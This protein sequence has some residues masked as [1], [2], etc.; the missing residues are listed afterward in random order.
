[1]EGTGRTLDY[2][3]DGLNRLTSESVAGVADSGQNGTVSYLLDKVGNRET[4]T[5]SIASVG[6]QLFTFNPRDQFNA[7]TYDANGNTTVSAGVS[8]TV[9]DTWDY[10]AF[11]N[12]V[13]RTGST[14]NAYL[15]RGE[16]FD[17]DLGMYSLRA[18]FYNQ[19]T[20]RFWN[21]DSYEGS[22]ADPGSLH[23]YLYANADPVGGWDPS[24]NFN[25]IDMM[26]SV[27]IQGYVRAMAYPRIFSVV[28]FAVSLIIPMEAQLGMPSFG[29]GG[30]LAA[31][32]RTLVCDCLELVDG[33]IRVDV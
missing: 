25:L 31:V 12:V 32:E 5:S 17:A 16:Q 9:T 23:K 15:Y 19:A 10:D 30:G 11:G 7:D 33:D 29:A 26:T 1:M 2:V 27:A 13:N 6:S 21:Q 3:Y 20:G 28:S 24:G 18:R 14:E 8:G 22:K 4:R